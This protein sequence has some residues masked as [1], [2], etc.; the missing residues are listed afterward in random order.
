M[1]GGNRGWRFSV[2]ARINHQQVGMEALLGQAL[3]TRLSVGAGHVR[4]ADHKDPATGLNARCQQFVPEAI[5]P[6]GADHHLVGVAFQSD[7]DP[8]QGW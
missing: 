2:F 7:G 5:Q 8:T 4:I 6:T 3:Q 1:D